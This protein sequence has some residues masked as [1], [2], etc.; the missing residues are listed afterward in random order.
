[1]GCGGGSLMEKL[2]E[3][4]I[5]ITDDDPEIRNL[6]LRTLEIK[7]FKNIQLFSSGKELLTK[8][9][10]TLNGEEPAQEI[11]IILDVIMPGDNGFDICRYI[12]TRWRGISVIL[13]SG[14]N[15]DDLDMKI[16]DSDADDFL[17]KPLSPTE[18][19]ARVEMLLKKKNHPQRNSSD[20]TRTMNI[21]HIGDK[22]GNY[23]ILDSLGWG[24]NSAIYK[25]I[26]RPANL[27]YALKILTRYS[28][29][30][31]EIVDRF[32]QETKIIE[33]LKHPN[34]TS[35]HASGD[36]GK[37]PYIVMEYVGGINLENYIITKGIP[38]LSVAMNAMIDIADALCYLHSKGIIHRDIKP[39]NI[40]FDVNR[41]IFK[42]TDF[43][44]AK[45]LADSTDITQDG[46]I[47]GT[48]MYMAPE[49]FR[50]ENPTVQS[51]IYSFAVSMYQFLSGRPPFSSEGQTDIYN[52][53][54]T[55]RP[56]YISEHIQGIPP[57][58]D[59]LLVDKCMAKHIEDRPESMEY[60]LTELKKI[61]EYLK[62]ES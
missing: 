28:L 60:I 62:D 5:Y 52:K 42:L 25:V 61:K 18:L 47:V 49:M 20:D 48:P 37:A 32:R 41:N 22:I 55:Q 45:D 34:L 6:I 56:K 8:M 51:D 58:L 57:A 16:L 29:E 19:S 4:P 3:S 40:M 11:L 31:K 26:E 21:P 27:I 44:I 7:G 54:L 39:K 38:S 15:I 13:V 2:L 46:F 30:F 17:S 14:F 43:G 36:F 50:G 12:K 10:E 1:M 59:K 33:Q 9:D 23:I 24:K 53:H 35:F